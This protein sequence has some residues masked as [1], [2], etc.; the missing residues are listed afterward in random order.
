MPKVA[1]GRIPKHC[2]HK[3]SGLGYVTLC[4]EQVYTG[5]YG[6]PEAEQAYREHVSRWLANGRKLP[7]GSSDRLTV[8][9]IA[10]LYDEHAG[11]YY[12]KAG[13]PTSYRKLVGRVMRDIKR[14]YGELP[15]RD[16][17]VSQFQTVR[18][19]WLR[20]SET[21]AVPLARRTV[22]T[23]ADCVRQMF[24]WA[25]ERGHISASIWSELAAVARLRKGRSAAS[26][27]EPIRPAPPDSVDAVRT[28][29]RAVVRDMIDLQLVTAMRPGEVCALRPCDLDRSRPVWMYTPASH[30]TEHLD[31][32]RAIPIG[33]KG[34][35]IL[36]PYLRPSMPTDRPIFRTV[37]GNA[38]DS[39]SYA[40]VITDVCNRLGVEHWTP[41]MLRHSAATRIRA[42]FGVE[43]AQ[44]ILGH[45]RVSTTEIYAEPD[46][47]KAIEV[48]ADF[49]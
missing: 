33:P 19:S 14:L 32:E 38:F 11:G 39:G 8:G 47:A 13:E 42:R 30:K 7:V 28:A 26:E 6:T 36:T 31:R 4:G 20:P 44:A 23:Q 34:Q 15:A 16:F 46:Y 40:T 3:H 29:V 17:G 22:N 12:R 27:T 37:R 35:A 48:I 2:L 5:K 10:D 24:R 9:R 43:A 1:E 18:D 45:S 41:N 25:A 49:G 21:R